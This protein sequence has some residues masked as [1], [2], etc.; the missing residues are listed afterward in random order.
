MTIENYL[1]KYVEEYYEDRV[2]RGDCDN[3]RKLF[4]NGKIKKKYP[5]RSKIKEWMRK[6]T[7]KIPNPIFG[8]IEEDEKEDQKRN[9]VTLYSPLNTPII[10]KTTIVA[11]IGERKHHGGGGTYFR[12]VDENGEISYSSEYS[13]LVSIIQIL[14]PFFNIP[15]LTPVKHV[16]NKKGSPKISLGTY[17]I[18]IIFRQKILTD[19]Y[20][21]ECGKEETDLAEMLP[22]KDR[23]RSYVSG[24]L[25]RILT[26]DQDK[27]MPN[28][29]FKTFG[30]SPND[31]TFIR[32]DGSFYIYDVALGICKTDALEHEQKTGEKIFGSANI[33]SVTGSREEIAWYDSALKH[34]QKIYSFLLQCEENEQKSLLRYTAKTAFFLSSLVSEV[35]KPTWGKIN[36]NEIDRQERT[37]AKEFPNIVRKAL[38]ETAEREKNEIQKNKFRNFYDFFIKEFDECKKKLM[39]NKMEHTKLVHEGGSAFCI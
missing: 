2:F 12:F 4:L 23:G 32:N 17:T 18:D 38:Y 34:A 16:K 33:N 5:V 10:A 1:R 13:S 29:N 37:H 39:L 36:D 11:E 8:A 14:A 6:I 21:T 3:A 20:M 19:A 9:S 35:K 7:G 28:V 26:D 31:N 25:I 30:D 27:P 15:R 22:I 24:S